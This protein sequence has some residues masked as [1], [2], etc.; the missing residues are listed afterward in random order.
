MP[1]HSAAA[2]CSP[3][4]RDPESRPSPCPAI[5]PLLSTD[6]ACHS[7]GV[8]RQA[9]VRRKPAVRVQAAARAQQ[10]PAA[11]IVMSERVIGA[12]PAAAPTSSGGAT[13]A[14]AVARRVVISLQWLALRGHNVQATGSATG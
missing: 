9:V 10:C 8:H 3:C 11:R 14:T 13:A 1:S 4:P 5:L 6:D 7:S 2:E 12:V